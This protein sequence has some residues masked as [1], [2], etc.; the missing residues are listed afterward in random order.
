MWGVPIGL[1]KLRPSLSIR[2][3]C[4][5]NVWVAIETAVKWSSRG[6]PLRSSDRIQI[7]E[8]S[9]ELKSIFS[10]TCL[11]CL[12]WYVVVCGKSE[13]CNR[14]TA[15]GPESVVRRESGSLDWSRA[16]NS[17]QDYEKTFTVKFAKTRSARNVVRMLAGNWSWRNTFFFSFLSRFAS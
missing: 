11:D 10:F 12:S 4:L 8:M 15:S 13:H 14:Q 2:A 6:R 3:L 16:K 5:R 7:V 1:F 17:E 9:C